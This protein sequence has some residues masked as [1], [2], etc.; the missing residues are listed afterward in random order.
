MAGQLEL[1]PTSFADAS[2]FV[3]EFHRHCEPPRGHKFSVGAARDGQLVG[4]VMV[5]RPVARGND[6]GW[7]LE[8]TRLC[9]LERERNAASFLLGAAARAAFAQ[10]YRRL[11]SYTLQTESGASMRAAGW[12]EVAAIKGRKWSCEARPRVENALRDKIRWELFA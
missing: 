12:H 9:V 8:V 7:T 5:G 11:C 4:V 3:D 6:D 2:R 10:G 1:V